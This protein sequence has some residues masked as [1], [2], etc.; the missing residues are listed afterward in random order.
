MQLHP[1]EEP[2]IFSPANKDELAVAVVTS[3]AGPGYHA[4][5]MEWLDWLAGALGTVWR[6]RNRTWATPPATGTTAAPCSSSIPTR[7]AW[8]RSPATSSMT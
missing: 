6:A 7:P 8:R 2:I 4:Y 3:N 5:A 1:A